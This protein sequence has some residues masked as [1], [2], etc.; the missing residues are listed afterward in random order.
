MKENQEQQP[1]ARRANLALACENREHAP[2]PAKIANTQERAALRKV[3][4]ME[5]GIYD[6]R[7]RFFAPYYRQ[8]A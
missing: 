8:A 4:R 1:R 2:W 5:K 3:I 7:S 6:A